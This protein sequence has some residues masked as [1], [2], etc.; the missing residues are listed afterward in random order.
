MPRGKG[1]VRHKTEARGRILDAALELFARKGFVGATTKEIA[2]KAE[3]NEV[4]LF[5]QFGS[6]KALYAAV[7][8]ERSPIVDI[9][10]GI[11]FDVDAPV[12]ELLIANATLVLST[13]RA[14][15]R[16]FMMLM[17]DAWRNPKARSM[18]SQFGME[19]GIAMATELMQALIEAGRI[20][21]M[22]PMIAARA[23]VGMVQS[24]FMTADLLAGRGSDPKEDK[25]ML[26]GFV[27]IFLDGAREGGKT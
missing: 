25:R 23:L 16:L 9:E 8:S 12:D 17:G 15:R 2:A 21:R 24:Y 13:L 18:I 3:V 4:T 22:D 7:I 14:N 20:R 26:S 27:G 5:R 10:K 6:K 11:S 19:K 1:A